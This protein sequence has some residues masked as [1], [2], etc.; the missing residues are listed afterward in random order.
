MVD[1]GPSA[2]RVDIVFIG[3]GYT[4]SQV[5]GIYPQHVQAQIDHLFRAGQ[6]P[7]PRYEK[8]FNVHR[9]DVISQ[10][11]G[12][13]K[14][15]LGIFVDTA[16]DASYWWDGVTERL[17]YFDT[18]KAQT[19][20]AAALAGTGID[21]DIRFG[22]VN[23]P[24]YGGGGGTWAVYAGANTSAL[25]VA[26]HEVGHSFGRLADE[27][28][29]PGTYNGPEPLEP[30]VTRSPSTGKWDRWL[31]YTDPSTNIG[32]I[33][34][35]EGARYFENGIY[36]PSNNSKMRSL[37]RPF[38]AVSREQ[39]ISQI[40]AE[41]DPLD[42]WLDNR[43]VLTDPASVWVQTVDPNVVAVDWLLDDQSLSV[44][45]ESIVIGALG[46]APG[47]YRLT[48]HAYDELLSHA[49]TGG[50][51]DWYRWPDTNPLQQSVT[52]DLIITGLPSG[53]FDGDGDFDCQDID[54]LVVQIVAGTNPP[55]YDMTG[56]NLVNREDRDAWLVAAGAAQLASGGSYLLGDANLDG[57]VDGSD[58]HVWNVHKLSPAAAW[59]Q[60]DFS[61]DGQVDG[62]DFNL[63][64]DHKFTHAIATCAVAEPVGCASLPWII[65]CWFAAKYRRPNDQRH[66]DVTAVT[67]DGCK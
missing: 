17:L 65:A 38:D 40:Y 11:S 33:G 24:K 45:G 59:C 49:F 25:E 66:G 9:V 6:Q 35:Y 53:D 21:V 56:D 10:Q 37:N 15:P 16:L 5:D 7:F 34:Y 58:F 14:P 43:D 44:S 64:N 28:F 57:S 4:A 22:T 13:D 31:G 27:Y 36:R 1:H 29:F 12:A 8:F 41:V 23:D 39:F 3:D 30:N 60:G 54:A 46:L 50:P 55:Q 19:A 47:S 63:W 67:I 26:L 20:V 51:W 61:A 48:A 18:G 32:P 52:W 2:N 42:G 62:T